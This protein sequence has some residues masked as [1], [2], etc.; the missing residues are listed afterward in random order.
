MPAQPR[1]E[2]EMKGLEGVCGPRPAEKGAKEGRRS[3]A[4]SDP[5]TAD[6]MGSGM[7]LDSGFPQKNYVVES[8]ERKLHET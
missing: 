7:R 2:D 6:R 1:G 8:R 4:G 3:P 5:Q